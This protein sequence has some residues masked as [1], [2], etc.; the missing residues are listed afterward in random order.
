MPFEITNASTTF[1][2][3][4]NDIFRPHLGKFVFIYLNDILVFSK[5]WVE[6]LHHVHSILEILRAHQL[7]VKENKSYFGQTSVHN[8]GFIL[9]TTGCVKIHLRYSI[10]HNG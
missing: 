10:W 9:A 8:L 1:I 6:H 5:S 7:Q 2:Q 3:L 4:I